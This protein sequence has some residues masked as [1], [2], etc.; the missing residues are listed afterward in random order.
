MAKNDVFEMKDSP[1]VTTTIQGG[2]YD[3][4]RLIYEDDHIIIRKGDYN[5]AALYITNPE[6]YN[7]DNFDEVYRILRS[8]STIQIEVDDSG[9]SKFGPAVCMVNSFGDIL[10]NGMWRASSISV[11]VKPSDETFNVSLYTITTS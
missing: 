1:V 3:P 11:A 9:S 5:N 8:C 7:P 10:I 4:G 6:T 2:S